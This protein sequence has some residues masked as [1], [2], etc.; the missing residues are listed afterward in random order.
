MY[1][2]LTQFFARMLEL[3]CLWPVGISV[4]CSP[5]LRDGF[6]ALWYTVLQACQVATL[7]SVMGAVLY[8]ILQACPMPSPT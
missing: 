6:L 7:L 3:S 1:M 8:T 4:G 5:G 2:Y